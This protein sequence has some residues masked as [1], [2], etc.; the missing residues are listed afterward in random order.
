MSQFP[1]L[2]KWKSQNGQLTDLTNAQITTDTII[3]SWVSHLHSRELTV[4]I[5]SGHF[6]LVGREHFQP[7]QNLCNT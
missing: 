3:P 5:L 7:A 2:I 4:L 1:K 6:I